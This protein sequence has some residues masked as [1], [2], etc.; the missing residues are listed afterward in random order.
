[1]RDARQ[2]SRTFRAGE[3]IVPTRNSNGG[4]GINSDVNRRLEELGIY[5]GVDY[6]IMTLADSNGN[7]IFSTKSLSSAKERQGKDI[8]SLGQDE[9]YV[10]GDCKDVSV[11]S[12]VFGTL[13]KENIVGRPIARIWPLNRFYI[14]GSP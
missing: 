2:I 13:P 3:V 14:G 7:S 4:D 6:R 11:D 8:Q 5:P 10:L 9:A 1:M 12:R